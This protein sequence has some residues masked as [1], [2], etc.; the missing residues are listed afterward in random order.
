MTTKTGR[1]ASVKKGTYTVAELASWSLDLSNDE[2]D[3]TVFGS[4]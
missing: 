4:T 2:I 1:N 3:T